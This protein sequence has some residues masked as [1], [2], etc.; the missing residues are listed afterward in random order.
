MTA[1]RPTDRMTLTPI[2]AAAMRHQGGPRVSRGHLHQ[3]IGRAGRT[4][5]SICRTAIVRCLLTSVLLSPAMSAEPATA[6]PLV[7]RVPIEN[8]R[9]LFDAFDLD[10]PGLASV[11]AAVAAGDFKLAKTSLLAYYRQR[12]S[13]VWFENWWER[14]S[15]STNAPPASLLDAAEKILAHDFTIAGTS[16]RFGERIEWR[17]LPAQLPDGTQDF[18]LPLSLYINRVPW[19]RDILG[20]AYWATGDERYATEWAA[21]VQDWVARNPAP[22]TFDEQLT[23]PPWR[24]LTVAFST[25]MWISAWNYFLQSPATTPDVVAAFF[26]GIIQKTRF[27]IRNPETASRLPVQIE[28]VHAAASYFPELRVASRWREW[29]LDNVTKYAGEQLYPDGASKD[30][31]PGYQTANLGAFRNIAALAAANQI[32]APPTVRSVMGRMMD[33]L[34]DIMMPD[35][36]L[37]A[38][39]DTWAPALVARDLQRALEFYPPEKGPARRDQLRYRATSGREGAPPASAST[40][41]PWAGMYLMRAPIPPDMATRVNAARVAQGG[42]AVPSGNWQPTDMALAFRCGPFGTDHQHEDKLSFVLYGVGARLLDEMGVYGYADT[43]WRE[44]FRGTAAH[45]TVLV[46]G[47]GQNRRARR[48][49]WT[50]NTPLEGNWT[51]SDAFDFVSGVYDDGWGPENNRAVSQRREIF[52]AKPDYWIVHDLLTG[53]GTHTYEVLYHLP[54]ANVVR[55]HEETKVAYTENLKRPNLVIYPLDTDLGIEIQRGWS[56]NP[57]NP[58]TP[59]QGWSSIA[60]QK[61]EPAPCVIQR[62]RGPAPQVIE[63]ILLPALPADTADIAVQRLRVTDGDGRELDRTAVCALKTISRAG[64][65]L[66]VNDLR[67]ANLLDRS[68]LPKKIA[69]GSLGEIEFNGKLLFIR[70]SPADLPTVVHHIGGD[71]PLRAGRALLPAGR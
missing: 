41:A 23:P 27:T 61:V 53:A 29:A 40:A 69:A 36:T 58:R 38:F 24:R 22:T 6:D 47:M 2:F 20:P 68:A 25:P 39:G 63:S 44:Y 30:L 33:Y 48:E 70:L 13:P 12:R 60:L 8:D 62:R 50:A 26:K 57:T 1:L 37:P 14:P 28:A 45:N 71:A 42:R 3:W 49:T 9:Q 15:R 4:A 65:H 7:P 34:G 55:V 31:A 21:L 51:S 54:P 59:R 18:Q 66:Y 11:K 56:A 35:G 67:M 16:A 46:D 5:H 64:T 52:F 43:P 10:H 17:H 19:W 32:P